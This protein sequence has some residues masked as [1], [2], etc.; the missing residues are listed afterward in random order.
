MHKRHKIYSQSSANH[1]GCLHLDK[2]SGLSQPQTS[3]NNHQDLDWFSTIK[4]SQR[5]GQYKLSKVH[6]NLGDSRR[7]PSPS[8][9]QITKSNEHTKIVG[10]VLCLKIERVTQKMAQICPRKLGLE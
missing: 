9:G 5:R 4:F 7:T 6:H 2:G 8:R 1:K 3:Q 10:E